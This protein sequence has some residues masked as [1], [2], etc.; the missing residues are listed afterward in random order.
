MDSGANCN[1][2]SIQFLTHEEKQTIDKKTVIKITGFNKQSPTTL[3][4]GKVEIPVHTKQSS[5]TLQFHVMPPYTLNYNLIGI[6]DIRKHFLNYL[7]EISKHEQSTTSSPKEK[8]A[9][10]SLTPP[11]LR[12]CCVTQMQEKRTKLKEQEQPTEDILTYEQASQLYAE[13]PA[14]KAEKQ[15]TPKSLINQK[16]FK[17]LWTLFPRLTM[18]HENLSEPSRLP[19]KFL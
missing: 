5:S 18:E 19:H 9:P 8:S 12:H 7:F 3:S 10:L 4:L 2:I 17:A 1:L 14:P 15:P 16:W 13:I 11:T 6:R